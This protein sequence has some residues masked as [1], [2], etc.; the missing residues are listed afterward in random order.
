MSSG[1]AHFSEAAQL[2]HKGCFWLYSYT[3][4]T[5]LF[6]LSAKKVVQHY[7]STAPSTKYMGESLFVVLTCCF[8][9][10][11]PPASL[12]FFLLVCKDH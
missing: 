3:S 10:V 4:S 12:T 11:A 5:R 7:T 6:L 1:S 9:H 8:S 2:A